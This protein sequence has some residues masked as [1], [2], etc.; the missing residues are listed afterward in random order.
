MPSNNELNTIS[1]APKPSQ[2]IYVSASYSMT[3]PL[4]TV[5]IPTKN[6]I[7]LFHRA[8]SSAVQ[9]DYPAIEIIVIDDGSDTTVSEVNAKL[10]SQYPQVRYIRNE[11]SIGASAA[12]NKAI[13]VASG[14]FITGLDDDDRFE[15][16]RI[17][18]FVSAWQK[19]PD[20]A[21]LCSCY[22]FHMAGSKPK[23]GLRR[24]KLIT[25]SSLK[26]KNEVGNQIF[27]KTEYL[28][29]IG[30]YDESL[31]ACQDYDL[32]LRMSKG[33]GTALRL[34]FASYHIHSE[35]DAPRISNF[36]QREKGHQQL[37]DKH[38]AEWSDAELKCQL[39]YKA[40]LCGE[41]KFSRLWRWLTIDTLPVY[42]LYKIRGLK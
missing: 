29:Q 35:H 17:T 8:L 39:F 14:E 12:R 37:I 18:Q 32:W 20:F 33:F 34:N 42:L 26:L 40:L 27:T 21:Y 28:R 9:Q 1:L 10:C 31:V 36:A 22:V 16:N 5:F 24:G 30:G 13:A 4:V 23:L 19:Q 6:R 25:Y 41:R 11:S 2:G 15:Q 7:E 3:L 38:K